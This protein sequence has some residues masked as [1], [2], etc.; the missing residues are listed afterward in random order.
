[1][2][3]LSVVLKGVRMVVVKVE[4]LVFLMVVN[5]DALWAEPRVEKR[6]L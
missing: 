2:V 1:M 3:L 6:V 5:W 4:S